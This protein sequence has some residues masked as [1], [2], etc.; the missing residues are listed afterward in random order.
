[1]HKLLTKFHFEPVQSYWLRILFIL[2]STEL[3]IIFKIALALLAHA[4]IQLNQQYIYFC[5]ATIGQI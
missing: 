5:I 2:I 1:M 4:A 3:N